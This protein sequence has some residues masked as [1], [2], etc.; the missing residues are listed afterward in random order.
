M[1]FPSVGILTFGVHHL[2]SRL[3]STGEV[4]QV[5]SGL[6]QPAGTPIPTRGLGVTFTTVDVETDILR[7]IH[8]RVERRITVLTHVQPPLN[9]LPTVHP[10]TNTARL[11]RILL[12]H[13]FHADSL[14]LRLVC[15]D[16]G[17]AVERPPVQVEIAVPTP[18][19]R[20]TSIVLAHAV[21]LTD[22]DPANPFLDTS[23]DDVFGESV[24]E[25]G[26]ALRPL[27]VQPSRPL[28]T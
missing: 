12:V 25:V 6:D 17:E 22:V 5:D 18:V 28:T 24:E 3:E 26:A 2:G 14:N 21:Q 20:L 19:L 1:G 4:V 27:L 9:T 11:R 16:T 23:L 15:E 13:L 10:T 7:P 8:I